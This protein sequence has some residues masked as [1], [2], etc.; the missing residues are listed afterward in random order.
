MMIMESKAESVLEFLVSYNT[1]VTTA[2]SF[3]I[4]E[5]RLR[6]GRVPYDVRYLRCTY[7]VTTSRCGIFDF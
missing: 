6:D 1:V 3:C 5:L 4:R 2:S 7:S